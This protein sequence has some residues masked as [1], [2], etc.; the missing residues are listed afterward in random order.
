MMMVKTRR[1][2]ARRGEKKDEKHR[3]IPGAVDA[4]SYLAAGLAH[5]Q[6]VMV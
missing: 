2:Q 1:D 6:K 5:G 4:C 3:R